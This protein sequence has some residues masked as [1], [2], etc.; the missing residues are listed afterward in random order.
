MRKY[1][2]YIRN[3]LISHPMFKHRYRLNYFKIYWMSSSPW[4]FSASCAFRTTFNLNESNK[5]SKKTVQLH[6]RSKLMRSVESQ[7]MGDRF[8]TTSS[9][10]RKFNDRCFTREEIATL[11]VLALSI[12][13]CFPDAKADRRK[14][15]IETTR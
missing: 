8:I 9:E 3:T 11:Q 1:R 6:S 13:H 15:S 4:R 7:L 14:K 5:I 2:Q 10:S 12:S